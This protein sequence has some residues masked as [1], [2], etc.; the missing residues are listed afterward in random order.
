M[1]YGASARARNK[2]P[3]YSF[4]DYDSAEGSHP[5]SLLPEQIQ[6]IEALREKFDPG[7]FVTWRT[8]WVYP[9]N[10]GALS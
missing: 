3:R 8:A 5:L 4:W 10:W 2:N 1:D 7:D 6:A 9:R